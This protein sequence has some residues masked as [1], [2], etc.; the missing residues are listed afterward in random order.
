MNGLNSFVEEKAPDRQTDH[1]CV[2]WVTGKSASL[3]Q[4]TKAHGVGA[5][6]WAKMHALGTCSVRAAMHGTVGLQVTPVTWC[7]RSKQSIRTFWYLLLEVGAHERNVGEGGAGMGQEGCYLENFLG[8]H[9]G[10]GEK[11]GTELGPG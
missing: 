3:N 2:R 1:P 8:P 7:R 9:L 4:V 11:K 5:L 10:R 6:Q